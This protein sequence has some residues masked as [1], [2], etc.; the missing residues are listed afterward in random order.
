M[1]EKLNYISYE[2]VSYNEGIIESTYVIDYM[3]ELVSQG[4]P[5]VFTLE[6]I[7]K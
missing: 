3:L 2:I 5:E 7:S 4:H 6:M 1:T